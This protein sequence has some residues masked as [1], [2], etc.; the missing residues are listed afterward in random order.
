MKKCEKGCII[1]PFIKAGRHI[2]TKQFTW[3]INCK[4]NC[5]SK[6][7]IYLIECSKCKLR[8]IG[9]SEREL[10]DRISEHVGYIRTNKKS[11]AS[12]EHFNLPGH[13][14]SNMKVTIIE[15]VL[16]QDELY[17]KERETIHIRK[18]N[19]FYNGLNKK[20]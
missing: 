11:E 17:R 10:K 8:Y 1:C 9:E 20:P 13:S 2:R 7:I 19:T 5:H 16:K 6:N 18:F 14:L 15:K 3:S 12:G 4:V